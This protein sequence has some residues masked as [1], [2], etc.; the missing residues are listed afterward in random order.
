MLRITRLVPI[1]AVLI[2]TVFFGTPPPA[3]AGMV[4]RLQEA[5]YGDLTIT[6]GGTTS[7]V[8]GGAGTG[9]TSTATDLDTS[10]GG[11]TI[12]GYSK[13][14]FIRFNDFTIQIAFG[15]SNRSD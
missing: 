10:E 5:G 13:N 7:Y 6:D 15:T 4:L 9:F 1:M 8:N 3:K 2:G 11:I 12:G 14:S